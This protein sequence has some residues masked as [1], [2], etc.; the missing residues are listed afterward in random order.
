[1]AAYSDTITLTFGDNAE[2]HVGMTQESSKIRLESGLGYRE[3]KRAKR[4]V[5]KDGG[6]AHLVDLRRGLPADQKDEV[7]AAYLLVIRCGDFLTKFD[8][9]SL[10]RELKAI[11]H[12]SKYYDTRRSK[13]LNKH[14]RHNICIADYSRKPDFEAKQ[15]TVV[16]FADLSAVSDLRRRI[17]QLLGSK[18]TDLV[19]ETNLYYD[20]TKCGIGFHGDTERKIVVGV[21]LG[22]SMPL[23]FQWYHQSERIGKRLKMTL[24]HGDM[25]VMAEKTVGNDWKKRS[26][27]T[28]RHAAGCPKYLK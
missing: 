2:N 3:L 15:G 24:H 4:R 8:A 7:E 16:D 1:M 5:E 6:K 23:H 13:V 11:S 14:A 9:K 28:L 19:A 20:I 27:L 25:Y 22:A 26:I 12:D 10:Y 21:R 18:A 17:G